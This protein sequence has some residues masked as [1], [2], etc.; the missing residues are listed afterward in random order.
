LNHEEYKVEMP[1]VKLLIIGYSSF[2]R[3]R[4]I[5]SIKKNKKIKY[6]ICSKSQKINLKARILF[7]DYNQALSQVS[8][9]IVYISLINSLHFMYAEIL[10]KKGFNVIVDKPITVSLRETK[11]LLKIAKSKNLLLSEAT[12][13]NY[14]R[15]FDKIIQL[16]GGKKNI[17][18][19]QSNLNHPLDKRKKELI[20]IKGDCELDMAP[21]AAS[22]IRLFTINKIKEL[23]VYREYFK[24][25]KAVKNFFTMIKL[26]DCT[27]FGNFGLDREYMHQMSFFTK[28]KIISSPGRLFALPPNNNIYISLKKENKI[29]YIKIKKDDCIQN[30]FEKILYAL[31]NKNFEFFYR[32]LIDDAILRD[33]IK[34]N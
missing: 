5:P 2:A 14:H 17:L 31:K 20:K 4:L 33:K 10:L 13:F 1:K 23:K 7:N 21:Y 32:T 16:C 30:F 25:T 11:K 34:N 8:P 26:K 12:L 22:I 6:Y 29:K 27:Y 24:R 9:D 18:H 28:N 19:I 15:V 3:R